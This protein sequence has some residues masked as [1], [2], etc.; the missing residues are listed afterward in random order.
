MYQEEKK[1]RDQRV[2]ELVENLIGAAQEIIDS[3]NE[4]EIGDIDINQLASIVY[5]KGDPGEAIELMKLL[6][7]AYNKYE[8]YMRELDD[9]YD[10]T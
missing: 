10:P 7:V 6:A 5:E 4:E 3:Q 2:K 8:K 1:D 9:Q